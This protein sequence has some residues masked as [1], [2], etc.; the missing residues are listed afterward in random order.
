[1][2]LTA[3]RFIEI[4]LSNEITAQIV[5]RLPSLKLAQ[6]MV[7]AGCLFQAVWNHVS[8]RPVA[9][10]VNDYDVFY[11]DEDVSWEAENRAI[12]AAQKLFQD[13]NVTVELRNQARVHLWFAD[14]FGADYPPLCSAKEGIDRFLISSTCVGLDTAT[15]ELYASHGLAELEQGI[16]RMNP[17]FP[18]P[19]QF[20]IKALSYQARWDWLRVAPQPF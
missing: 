6:C 11:F 12:V 2:T 15:G 16:L 20:R 10:G 8:E 1:M 3:T 19:D 13:L 9:W 5:E 14:R 18:Q 17:N 7:T 4:A